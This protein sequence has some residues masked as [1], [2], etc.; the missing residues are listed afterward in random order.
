MGSL[1]LEPSGKP[2]PSL[3][4]FHEEIYFLVIRSTGRPC[5]LQSFQ[6][7]SL[8]LSV[9]ITSQEHRQDRYCY[10]H[11]KDE[12][13]FKGVQCLICCVVLSHSVVSDSLKPL[14]YRP[15]RL[16]CPWGFSRQEYWSGLPCP[17]P[18]DLPNPRTEP[19]SPALQADSLPA[20][21]P[22]KST[23]SHT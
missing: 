23:G 10:S 11:S 6:G 4:T 3:G 16:L 19:R 5:L 17:P 8:S 21:P 18:G 15:S 7:I 1:P 22:G 13:S 12:K 9:T 20:E 2:K 14:D